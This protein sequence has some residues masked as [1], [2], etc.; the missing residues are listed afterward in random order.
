MLSVST[1]ESSPSVSIVHTKLA[2]RTLIVVTSTAIWLSG[3]LLYRWAAPSTEFAPGIDI[4]YPP[5][6]LRT[7]LLIVGGIWSALGLSIA[8]FVL[9]P[10]EFGFGD[11]ASRALFSIYAGFAPYLATVGSFKLIGVSRGLADLKPQ[12][13]PL[14]CFGVALGSSLLHV[15]AFCVIGTVQWSQFLTATAAMALGDFTGCLVVILVALGAIKAFRT[16]KAT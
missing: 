6:G 3:S 7:L 15:I 13:L 1:P 8:N 12:H 5:A 9:S 4:I 11:F 14:L 16:L 10:G 2:T